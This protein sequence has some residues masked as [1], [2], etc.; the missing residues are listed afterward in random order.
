LHLD[1][2]DAIFPEM[3]TTIDLDARLLERAKRLAVG[4]RRTLSAVVNDA[5]VAYLGSKRATAK[6]PPFE[7]LVRGKPKGR[8]PTPAEVAALEDEEDIARLALP[9]KGRRAAS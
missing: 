8:F 6:D 1:A 2:D 7:L 3:R 4:E 9:R 5:L